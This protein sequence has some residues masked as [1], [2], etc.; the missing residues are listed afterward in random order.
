MKF[1]EISDRVNSVEGAV[2]A[3]P[4]NINKVY[5]QYKARYIDGDRQYFEMGEEGYVKAGTL[6]LKSEMPANT[7]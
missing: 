1:T 2:Q 7:S 4:E 6:A 3:I 5:G